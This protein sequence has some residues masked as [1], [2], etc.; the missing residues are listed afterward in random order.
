[1]TLKGPRKDNPDWVKTPAGGYR[2]VHSDSDVKKSRIPAFTSTAADETHLHDL[3]DEELLAEMIREKYVGTRRDDETGLT[4]YNY[5]AACQY[6]QEWNEVTKQA[7][8]LIVDDNGIIVARPF[9]KFFNYGHEEMGA[10]SQLDLNSPAEVTDK[11]D[12]SLGILLPAQYGSRISTRGSLK[13]D[14][15]LHASK[16]FARKYDHSDLDPEVT[17][18]FEII[19]PENKIVLDYSDLDDV[20]L[21]G[22]VHTS[23]GEI[24][25]AYD[26]P[27]SGER[28]ERFEAESLGEALELPPRK[29]SEGLVIRYKDSGEMVKIK[30]DDYVRLHRVAFGLSTKSVWDAVRNGQTDAMLADMPDEFHDWTRKTIAN[31]NADRDAFAKSIDEAYDSIASKYDFDT[32]K[33]EFA[34][35]AKKDHKD[36]FGFI[37]AKGTGKNVEEAI[38]KKV[39]PNFERA[40]E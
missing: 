17:Y 33:K 22:G 20:V 31:L 3:L 28:T 13:S 2:K 35:N 18:H 34:I 1:M 27:W 19:Y 5:T 32:Q 26:L 11:M 23:T 25:S 29:N 10:G 6:A 21:L 39:K 40:S 24:V 36:L 12:G 14:Q 15:A 9:K 7:R 30:Q 38:W 16:L 4:V 37:M 8:G